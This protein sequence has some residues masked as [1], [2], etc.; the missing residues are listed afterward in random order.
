M[1]CGTLSTMPSGL[2]RPG[3][4][5]VVV[6]AVDP[7]IDHPVAGPFAGY[8]Y[9]L[10]DAV[11]L[12]AQRPGVVSLRRQDVGCEEAALPETWPAASSSPMDGAW[13]FA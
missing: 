4:A 2:R 1:I 12:V 5:R 11:L 7:L 8:R 10:V 3:G 9:V 6:E 13:V